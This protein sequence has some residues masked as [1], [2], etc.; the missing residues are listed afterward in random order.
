MQFFSYSRKSDVLK[1]MDSNLNKYN[2]VFNYVI[3]YQMVFYLII[4]Y[5]TKWCNIMIYEMILCHMIW[6]NFVFCIMVLYHMLYHMIFYHTI[7]YSMI[8]Y[9]I[10]LKFARVSN[11]SVSYFEVYFHRFSCFVSASFVISDNLMFNLSI[12]SSSYRMPRIENPSDE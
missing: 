6:Y 8:L 12:D 7:L 5:F 10:V 9:D 4:L 1:Q 2:F 11:N 3:W